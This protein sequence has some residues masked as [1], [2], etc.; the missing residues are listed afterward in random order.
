MSGSGQAPGP[1][2][3]F[4]GISP[5]A[6]AASSPGGTPVRE[7][8][9]KRARVGKESTAPPASPVPAA[10]EGGIPPVGAPSTLTNTSMAGKGRRRGKKTRSRRSRRSR[11]TRRL[12]RIGG[13]TPPPPPGVARLP[14]FRGSGKIRI[15]KIS[16]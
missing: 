11:K 13:K 1:G 5:I 7:P 16:S 8:P 4:G 2:P 6:S 12:R 3:D 14:S 9:A 10:G 15:I